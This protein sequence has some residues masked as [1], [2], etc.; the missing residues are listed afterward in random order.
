MFTKKETDISNNV[1]TNPICHLIASATKNLAPSR[2]AKPKNIHHSTALSERIIEI[3]NL[4]RSQYISR[5]KIIWI[6]NVKLQED[7]TT[8]ET[9]LFA[10][11]LT[12]GV[13]EYQYSSLYDSSTE[14]ESEHY[15]S[16]KYFGDHFRKRLA[17]LANGI[18]IAHGKNS[19]TLIKSIEKNTYEVE[20]HQLPNNMNASILIPLNND[21]LILG[22]PPKIDDRSNRNIFHLINTHTGDIIKEI[23]SGGSSMDDEFILVGRELFC[24]TEGCA[25]IDRINLLTGLNT[26]LPILSNKDENFNPHWITSE[27]QVDGTVIVNGI[28]EKN[29]TLVRLFDDPTSPDTARNYIFPSYCFA[30]LYFSNEALLVVYNATK[31]AVELWNLNLHCDGGKQFVDD[32]KLERGKL[33]K[34]PLFLNVEDIHLF[35][36]GSGEINYISKKCA[37]T[38]VISFQRRMENLNSTKK[39]IQT[40]I[41]ETTNIDKNTATII[42]DYTASTLG[43]FS[44]TE[45]PITIDDVLLSEKIRFNEKKITTL[46]N[47][48]CNLLGEELKDDEEYVSNVKEAIFKNLNKIA[49]RHPK[50]RDRIQDIKTNFIS[51]APK[52]NSSVKSPIKPWG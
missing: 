44:P 9:T 10:I 36:N 50:F 11:N 33:A 43:L 5:G 51:R 1:K 16:C 2:P 32:V 13:I 25:R 49:H 15:G 23:K 48:L 35:D 18:V 19:Y 26:S 21:I 40:H 4:S 27:I 46:E 41:L 3:I 31:H 47:Q 37:I 38:G 7:Q 24:K 20:P 8:L 17:I 30:K 39:E 12:T 6:P 14:P 42:S 29:N 28:D 22:S 52:P 34:T 45:S